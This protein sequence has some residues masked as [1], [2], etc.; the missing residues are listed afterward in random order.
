MILIPF[1]AG[2]LTVSEKEKKTRTVCSL[3]AIVFNR[4]DRRCLAGYEAEVV[5]DVARHGFHFLYFRFAIIR[6]GDMYSWM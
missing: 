6:N 5:G 4:G 3:F 1:D 2:R